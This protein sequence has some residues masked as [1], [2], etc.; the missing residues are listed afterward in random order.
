MEGVCRR[1]IVLIKPIVSI[2]QARQ[3]FPSAG[4]PFKT[5][6]TTCG[7]GLQARIRFRLILTAGPNGLIFS[8]W[9]RGAAIRSSNPARI[10]GEAAMI[11]L[12]FGLDRINT[13]AGFLV[14]KLAQ[15]ACVGLITIIRLIHG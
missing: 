14:Q 9:P 13:R 10:P 7:P 8:G 11:G 4:D 2:C 15:I 12:F 3:A 5:P 6:G 1:A